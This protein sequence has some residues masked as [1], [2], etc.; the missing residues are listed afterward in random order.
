MKTCSRCKKEKNIE[1]FSKNKR[2]KCGYESRCK[3]CVRVGQSK[4]LEK[5][6]DSMREWHRSYSGLYRRKN[7][8]R[9]HLELLKRRGCLLAYEEF[10]SWYERQTRECCYC[11]IPEKVVEIIRWGYNLSW[12]NKP[13][14]LFLTIDRKNS[15]M[16]YLID[17]ICFSCSVCN[18][19]KNHFFTEEEF[20][21]IAIKY[22]KPKWENSLK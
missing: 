19:L 2:N 6:R 4:W 3:D 13:S 20:K 7:P 17:N 21:E 5:H 15:E 12:N 18:S 10:K 11:H 8:I 16:G 1:C 22:I 14:I 9:Y